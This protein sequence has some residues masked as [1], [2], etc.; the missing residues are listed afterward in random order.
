MF[1]IQPGNKYKL[2]KYNYIAEEAKTRTT[3]FHNKFSINVY[4]TD[5]V[6]ASPSRI[7]TIKSIN[8][9]TNRFSIEEHPNLFIKEWMIQEHIAE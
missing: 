4:I 7:I 6:E 3:G 9:T 5:L 2:H 8:N 1:N